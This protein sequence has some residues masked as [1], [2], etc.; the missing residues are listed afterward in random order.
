M[1][2][3]VLGAAERKR[4]NDTVDYCEVHSV[5]CRTHRYPHPDIWGHKTERG[6]WFMTP[7]EALDAELSFVADQLEILRELSRVDFLAQPCKV[8]Q[9]PRAEYRRVYG[10]ST[11]ADGELDRMIRQKYAERNRQE[12]VPDTFRRTTPAAFEE[13]E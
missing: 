6:R 2:I 5:G 3:K 8:K 1:P 9:M 13:K 11:E 12:R 7:D 10:K 4:K